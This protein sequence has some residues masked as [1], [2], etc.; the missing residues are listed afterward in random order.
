MGAG[1]LLLS[2]QRVSSSRNYRRFT[3]IFPVISQHGDGAMNN[4][5]THHCDERTSS[6]VDETQQVQQED[7][8]RERQFLGYKSISCTKIISDAEHREGT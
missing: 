7:S 8:A 3:Q 1:K 5:F 4:R 2:R 6:S